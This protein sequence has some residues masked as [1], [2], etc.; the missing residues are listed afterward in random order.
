MAI[1]MGVSY[2]DYNSPLVKASDHGIWKAGFRCPDVVLE[3]PSK[4]STWLYTEAT[5]GKYLVLFIGKDQSA[6]LGH[7]DVA[8]PYRIHPVDKS[9]VAQ[10]NGHEASVEEGSSKSFQADWVSRGD[11]I[12][13]IVR[14]DMYIGCVGPD[15]ESCKQ[16]L[17]DLYD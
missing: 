5:Y 7:E 3:S 2:Q 12:V 10:T 6:G 17:D 15:V 13:V 4:G 16:Y 8:V 1:G 11:S 14:P 9:E